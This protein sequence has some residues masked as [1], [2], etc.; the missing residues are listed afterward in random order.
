MKFAIG[1]VTAALSIASTVHA[2]EIYVRNARGKLTRQQVADVTGLVKNAVKGM[3]EHTLVRSAAEADFTLQP[4]VITRGDELVLRVEKERN[5]EILSMSEEGISSVNASRNRAVSVTETA[6]SDSS[7]G[8]A[9][10]NTAND[11][12]GKNGTSSA[13]TSSRA[14]SANDSANDTSN[15]SAVQTSGEIPSQATTAKSS[16]A[17]ASV[18]ELTSASPRMLNPDRIGQ[19]QLGVGTSFGINMKDDSL[20]YDLMAGYAVD[21]TE[22]FVGKVFGDFNLATGSSA[23]RFINLGL[24]GEYYPTKELLTFGKPYLAADLGYAFTR[25]GFSRTGDGLAAGV[26]AG[27]KFQAAEMNW[28][29]AANYSL[30]LSQVADETPSVFGVRVAL[31]F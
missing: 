25:D 24:A 5:G 31:G 15:D 3:S 20:M 30:L 19:I 6:L 28:D 22:N 23:T 8:P 29:V 13:M 14:D 27:F 1:L 26:G 17:D 4:S 2:S 7:F 12:S 16:G 11:D 18:G 9:D 10:A 21:F